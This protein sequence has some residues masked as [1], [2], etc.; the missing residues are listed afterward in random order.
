MKKIAICM[1]SIRQAT[2]SCLIADALVRSIF[3]VLFGHLESPFMRAV[4]TWMNLSFMA[5]ACE[6]F[7]RRNG[8]GRRRTRNWGFYGLTVGWLASEDG[9]ARRYRFGKTM[10]GGDSPFSIG[11]LAAPGRLVRRDGRLLCR[12]IGQ[13]RP[14]A[15]A[16]IDS[17]YEDR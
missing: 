10:T 14:R 16:L 15:F 1:T 4:P 5:S 13:G 2:R 3:V 8:G 6:V 17:V 12:S 9:N 11:R 7:D